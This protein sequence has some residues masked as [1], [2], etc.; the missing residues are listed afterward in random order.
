MV[1]HII[2]RLVVVTVGTLYPA[3]RSFKAM[4]TKNVREYVKWMMYWVVFACFLAVETVAD[5]FVSWAIPFYYELKIVFV[6][7]L[8]WPVTKGS[9]ILYRKFVHP[10]LIKNEKDIDKY[11]ASAADKGFDV[12]RRFSRSG[13]QMATSTVLQSNIVSKGQQ[14]VQA[15]ANVTVPSSANAE[16]QGGNQDTTDAARTDETDPLTFLPDS[17]VPFTDD[18]DSTHSTKSNFLC[19]DESSLNVPVINSLDAYAP[20]QMVTRQKHSRATSANKKVEG[21]RVQRRQQPSVPTEHKQG[22]TGRRVTVK[23]TLPTATK[24]SSTKNYQG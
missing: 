21:D 4:K 13:L 20:Q 19:S 16:I 10:Y 17:N 14:L 12:M 3:Y 15:Y 11:L 8:L 6:I 18:P 2:S 7:W 1:S 23:S 9:S 22:V 5:I 24:R